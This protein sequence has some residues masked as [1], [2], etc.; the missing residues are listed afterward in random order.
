MSA[1]REIVVVSDG[2]KY[3]CNFKW[4][5][6]N[7]CSFRATRQHPAKSSQFSTN[8]EVWQ[9][10]MH[11]E[12]S[13]QQSYFY[14]NIALCSATVR[15][16]NVNVEFSIVINGHDC[17]FTKKLNFRLSEGQ[18]AELY[19]V[20]RQSVLQW[21]NGLNTRSNVL[22]VVINMDNRPDDTTETNCLKDKHIHNLNTQMVK[23]L[24]NQTLAD[25]TLK[26]EDNEFKAHKLILAAAS[27]VFEA[28]FKDGTKEHR[29]NY[30]NIQDMDSDVFDVF[31]RFL[32]SGQVEHL[33]EMYFDLFAAADKYDVQPLRKFALNT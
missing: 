14:F 2:P 6:P 26:V 33:D 27:P 8:G 21:L 23:M 24:T 11:E 17:Y 3:S 22:T 1:D 15:Y 18:V 13:D 30:V 32:Y 4:K 7:V 10:G 20:K 9:L 5:V 19:N 12:S 28:M 16:T 31:L 29:D 25:V